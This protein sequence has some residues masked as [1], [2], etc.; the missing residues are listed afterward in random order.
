MARYDQDNGEC[1]VFTY[2]EGLLS[3]VAHDLKIRVGRWELTVD[4]EGADAVVRGTF[5]PTSLSVVCAMKD[6]AESRGTIGGRDLQKIEK[7]IQSDVLNTRR[8]REIGFR[9]T[10]V[11]ESGEGYRVSGELNL[12]GRT[13]TISTQVRR[14]GERLVAELRINQPDFGIKPFSAMLG[15]LKI[16]PQVTVRLTVP[17]DAA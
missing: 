4:G 9:S 14:E 5:D 16:Q 8:H 10:G 7:N 3:A 11:E 2:K 1:L 15:T 13:R 6:G 17:A 12:A